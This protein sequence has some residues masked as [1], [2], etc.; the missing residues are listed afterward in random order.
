M[1]TG[2]P[3]RKG[4]GVTVMFQTVAELSAV[5]VVVQRRPNQLPQRRGVRNEKYTHQQRAFCSMHIHIHT[6]T[7]THAHTRAPMHTHAERENG[8]RKQRRREKE[9]VRRGKE[10]SRCPTSCKRLSLAAPF[11]L[12][13]QRA[14]DLPDLPGPPLL[15]NSAKRDT[16]RGR[17]MDLCERVCVHV[18]A[19]MYALTQ[20][21]MYMCTCTLCICPMLSTL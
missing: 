20:P 1:F 11:P 21:S 14:A 18:R 5:I 15:R 7:Q 2:L 8:G 19:S 10:R 6:H 9:R 4:A 13:F 16:N 17:S 12:R 3:T